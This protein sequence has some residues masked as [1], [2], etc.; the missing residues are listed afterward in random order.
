MYPII[1]KIL[2][3]ILL[4]LSLFLYIHTITALPA[5]PAQPQLLPLPPTNIQNQPPSH[6]SPLPAPSHL[7]PTNLSRPTPILTD[8]IDINPSLIIIIDLSY[9]LPNP[10]PLFDLFNRSSAFAHASIAE[11]GPNATLPGRIVRREGELEY[12]VQPPNVRAFNHFTWEAY[13]E[14]TEWLFSYLFFLR[15]ERAC[16]F[17]VRMRLEEG[18]ERQ[19][20][21]GEVGMLAGLKD[22][23]E[24]VPLE[25]LGFKASTGDSR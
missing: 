18:G 9:P 15:N 2:L 4:S 13:G 8:R 5:S 6:Q 17:N 14:V 11:H 16:A 20:G 21:Y 3:P 1:Q 25:P 22:G 23:S 19:I 10:S 24:L 12:F 7:Q